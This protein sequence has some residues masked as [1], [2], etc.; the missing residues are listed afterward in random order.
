M[1]RVRRTPGITG[2][3][4][5]P[6]API[7][8]RVYLLYMVSVWRPLGAGPRGGAFSPPPCK[9]ASEVVRRDIL[10]NGPLEGNSQAVIDTNHFSLAPADSLPHRASR[11][12]V[13]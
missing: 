4:E 3:G 8:P 5:A 12:N 9:V 7:I 6:G 10:L 11:L 1:P 2:H 13:L